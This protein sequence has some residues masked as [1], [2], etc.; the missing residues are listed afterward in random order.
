MGESRY[1]FNIF[2]LGIRWSRVISFCPVR[3]IPE[4][5]APCAHWTADRVGSRASLDAVR[6]KDKNLL[7]LPGIESQRSSP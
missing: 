7:L 5:R 4:E 6:K 1:S 3:F 2:D